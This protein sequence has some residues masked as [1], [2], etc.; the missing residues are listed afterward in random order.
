MPTITLCRIFVRELNIKS[1]IFVVTLSGD[2]HIGTVY[3][4]TYG[5]RLYDNVTRLVTI[6]TD[7]CVS[8]LP[9]VR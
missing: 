2:S 3:K 9:R 1:M 6:L 5:D 4:V 7:L 8:I